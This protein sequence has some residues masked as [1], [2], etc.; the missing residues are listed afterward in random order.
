MLKD[1]TKIMV[2]GRAESLL[3]T[4][5]LFEYMRAVYLG[6]V[7]RKFGCSTEEIQMRIALT[8]EMLCLSCPSYVK[9]TPN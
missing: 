9:I 7:V 5:L 2:I 3:Q 1:K 6:S 4:N 8:K